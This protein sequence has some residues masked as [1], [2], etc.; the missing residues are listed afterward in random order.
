MMVLCYYY[1]QKYYPIPYELKSV[2]TY[3]IIAGIFIVIS[4]QIKIES[5]MF[6]IPFHILLTLLF[7]FGIVVSERT[8]LGIRLGGTKAQKHK[9]SE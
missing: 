3:L 4:W 7:V 8:S 9:G 2:I 1:G 6:S 5:L